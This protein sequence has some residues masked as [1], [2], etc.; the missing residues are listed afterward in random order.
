MVL[1]NYTWAFT[2]ALSKKFCDEV[3]KY[4]L[5]KKL[6][7]GVT[8]DNTKIKNIDKNKRPINRNSD[9]GWLKEQWIYKEISPLVKMA[10]KDAGWNFQYDKIEQAQFTKYDSNQFFDWH[11]DMFPSSEIKRKISVTC[12]LTDP[13]NYEGGEIEFDFKNYPPEET[14]IYK[15]KRLREKGTVIVFPSFVWH[16]VKPVT[17]GTRYSLVLWYNGNDWQ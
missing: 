10:N 9:I 13:N 2:S 4:A 6:E 11:Q 17:K 7:K 14:K 3:V 12:Q 16:R 5:Q 8:G 15:D 1:D